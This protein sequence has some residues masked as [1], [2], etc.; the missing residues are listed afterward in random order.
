MQSESYSAAFDIWTLGVLLYEILVGK[1]PF[2]EGGGSSEE[3]NLN[4]C[5]GDNYQDAQIMS[6]ILKGTF[7][8]PSHISDEASDLIK[9]LL[10]IEPSQRLTSLRKIMQHPWIV[11]YCGQTTLP[12]SRQGKKLYEEAIKMTKQQNKV[13]E[14]HESSQKSPSKEEN[15]EGDSR[16]SK[17]TSETEAGEGR[18]RSVRLSKR[19]RSLNEKDLTKEA[20]GE[21]NVKE[22][23]TAETRHQPKIRKITTT[24]TKVSKSHMDRDTVRRDGKTNSSTQLRSTNRDVPVSSKGPRRVLRKP[25]ANSTNRQN[26]PT[27][28][29]PTMV[30][31]T[32]QPSKQTSNSLRPQQKTVLKTV[33]NTTGTGKAKR[34][35]YS[36]SRI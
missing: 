28:K 13:T 14:T 35:V 31:V 30:K 21:G 4:E 17:Q 24:A 12:E 15:Q 3:E 36:R 29:A 6:R 9:K 5:N 32:T 27:V 18:R 19:R 33:N 26:V 8:I 16:Q 34:S 22:V 7:T 25:L 23:A 2:V 10:T 1:T 11:R 20:F